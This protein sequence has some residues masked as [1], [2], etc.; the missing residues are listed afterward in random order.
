MLWSS[1]LARSEI[2][3]CLFEQKKKLLESEFIPGENMLFIQLSTQHGLFLGQ[4][5]IGQQGVTTLSYLL[6][7]PS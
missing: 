4:E 5:K 7:F 3:M 2:N 6:A 1:V